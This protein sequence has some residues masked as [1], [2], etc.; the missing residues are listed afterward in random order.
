[1]L[2]EHELISMV[3]LLIVAGHE[4]TVNLIGNGMLA[5]LRNSTQLRRLRA[6]PSLVTGAVEELLRYDGPVETSTFR[7]STA[8]VEL[9]GGTIPAGEVVLLV[10]ASANRDHTRFADADSLDITRTGNRHLAFGKGMHF[11]LG[12]AL[13][14]MEGQI[15]IATLLRRLPHLRPAVRLDT[16]EWRPSLLIRGLRTFPVLF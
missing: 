9:P 11:C 3:F 12:A 2:T 10:L 6:D 16:L 15:A 8:D 1:V 7:F 14:R 5:L 4:T 13:A